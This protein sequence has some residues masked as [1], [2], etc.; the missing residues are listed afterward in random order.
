MKLFDSHCHLDDRRYKKD[1]DDVIERCAASGVEAGPK[2]DA[3]SIIS[4]QNKPMT[5][6]GSLLFALSLSSA[7]AVR[8]WMVS[9]ESM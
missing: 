6:L 9:A 1:L 3:S 4:H 2:T 7:S 5:R 8:G